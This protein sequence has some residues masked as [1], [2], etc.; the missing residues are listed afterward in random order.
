MRIN[1]DM[2]NA[3]QNANN[4]ENEMTKFEIICELRDALV[5]ANGIKNA[6][7]RAENVEAVFVEAAEH[8][9]DMP[10]FSSEFKSF[11]E[12]NGLVPV[13]RPETVEGRAVQTHSTL[14]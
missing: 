2:R 12:F 10:G 1:K 3:T 8:D 4:G 11:C 7:H 9:E 13:T 5:A 14:K 6:Y